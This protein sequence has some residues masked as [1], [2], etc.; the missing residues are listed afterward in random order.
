MINKAVD[1]LVLLY[2]S[3]SWLV[4]GEM[5]KVLGGVPPPGG[6]LDHGEDKNTWGGQGVGIS[7]CGD[8][9]GSRGTTPQKGVH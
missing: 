8:G 5:L 1:Q 4:T 7:S 6:H 2:G 3:E 9:T